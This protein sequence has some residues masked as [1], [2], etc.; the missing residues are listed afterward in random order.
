MARAG[1][2]LVR[3]TRIRG[4]RL[5][6]HHG[7]RS[8]WWGLAS[9]II[10]ESPRTLQPPSRISARAVSLRAG[11]R[12]SP[13]TH[14]SGARGRG[15][16]GARARGS[17]PGPAHRGVPPGPGRPAT[18]R[19]ASRTAARCWAVPDSRTA[20][21]AAR[22]A[23][24]QATACSRHRAGS[25][26]RASLRVGRSRRRPAPR[27]VRPGSG[28]PWSGRPPA[29]ARRRTRR[30]TGGPPPRTECREK[31]IR[32]NSAIASASAGRSHPSTTAGSR[33]SSAIRCSARDASVDGLSFGSAG[34]G[35]G[36]TRAS[37]SRAAR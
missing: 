26:R 18:G 6:G 3:P 36:S 30:S 12:P 7:I 14:R 1:R 27:L 15:A 8:R 13:A 23:S 28:S 17:R 19:A 16:I 10:G 22:S 9:P 35:P 34:G 37:A 25:G 21:D 32:A 20:A 29:S 33:G 31:A 4:P 11:A 5:G 24:S 2:C